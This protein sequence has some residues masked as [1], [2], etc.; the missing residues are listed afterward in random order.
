[1]PDDVKAT[2]EVTVDEGAFVSN[3]VPGSAAD[4]GGLQAGDVIVAVDGDD[5]VEA[6]D[7]RDKILGHEPGDTVEIDV[8]RKGEEKTLEVTLGRRGDT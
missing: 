6:T 7:V 3:V 2:F 1:V 4:K 8:V 5:I